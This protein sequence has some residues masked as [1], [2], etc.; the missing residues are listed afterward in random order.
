MSNYRSSIE[1]LQQEKTALLA[2]QQGG[3]GER[4]TLIAK[5]QK[6][7]AKAATLVADAAKT[8]KREAD[9]AFDRT[10]AQYGRH[11]SSRL[12]SYLPH[13]AAVSSELSAVKGELLLA[14]VASKASMSLSGVASVLTSSIKVGVEA[15]SEVQGSVEYGPLDIS[16][17]TAQHIANTLHE[18][19]FAHLAIETASQAMRILAAGQWPDLL[20][21]GGSAEL[22][23]AVLRSMPPVDGAIGEQL[24]ILK[25]EGALSSHRSN[26]VPLETSVSDAIALLSSTTDAES[27][28][29]L[30]PSDWSPFGWSI[31]QNASSARFDCLGSAAA[32]A[33]AIA[34]AEDGSV[35][36]DD[37]CRKLSTLLV[38]LDQICTESSQAC[39]VLT[40]LPVDGEVD[41]EVMTSL[42]GW[43]EAAASL[44]DSIKSLFSS[45]QEA[46]EKIIKDAESEADGTLRCVVKL[47]SA[48]RSAKIVAEEGKKAHSLSPEVDDPWK[49]VASV[50]RKVRDEEDINYILRA[51]AVESKLSEAIDS[52]SKLEVA[53]NK[54]ARLEK[55]QLSRSKEISLQN[56]RL[57]ELEQMLAASGVDASAKSPT[58]K[59]KGS[60]S[61]EIRILKDE[62]RMLTE[63]MDVL[64]G[65][66]D[67]YEREIRS[68]KDPRAGKGRS[69]FK[70][71]PKKGG[72]ADFDLQT[73]LS[74]LGKA[75]S[76]DASASASSLP[77]MVALEAA[78]FRPALKSARADASAWKA[79][80]IASSIMNLAPLTVPKRSISGDVER[81][82]EEISL[83]NNEARLAK[84]SFR[85]VD[86]T[87]SK[88]G[89]PSR[90]QLRE[91]LA[92]TTDPVLRLDEAAN[93][94]RQMLA[95]L[96]ASSD[97]FI[98]MAPMLQAEADS[99]SKCLG[100][101]RLP[102]PN[103]AVRQLS[104]HKNE[105]DLLHLLMLQ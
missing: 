73:S 79:K 88:A 52:E 62:N 93:S 20:S 75:A 69:G 58:K 23:A 91:E 37:T 22:G 18:T 36:S 71:T 55:S 29:L 61:D 103:S 51:H 39:V 12:E 59:G 70:K 65:Q 31:L 40:G 14:K 85:V 11:L 86:L 27:G 5:S 63:A 105:L 90:L 81:F 49:G 100:R 9:A 53:K 66:V 56:S 80:A 45:P 57:S 32:V 54:V 24:R 13:S 50:V 87:K 64:H 97:A 44:M 77:K 19:K 104:V 7:L 78:L 95:R 101:L 99:S 82:S 6:A 48:I 76:A 42:T 38:K 67:E 72:S 10:D 4:S 2:L 43:K 1:K 16:D 46:N 33:V 3:E 41:T 8:R 21:T 60:T 35:A 26:L 94:A 96:G 15:A 83:A 98:T 84:A 30:I 25:E 47:S 17:D 89:K 92:R 34:S 28:E 102:G 74:K 68:L